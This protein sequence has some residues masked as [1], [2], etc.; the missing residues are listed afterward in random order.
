MYLGV[1]FSI[2]INLYYLSKKKKIK[3]DIL[4]K[5]YVEN[6]RFFILNSSEGD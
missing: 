5:K 3:K 1:S 2:S 4:L 6:E